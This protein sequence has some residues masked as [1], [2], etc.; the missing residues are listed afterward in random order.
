MPRVS[1]RFDSEPYLPKKSRFIAIR[2]SV[3][4]SVSP[5]RLFS[6]F[7]SFPFF[8]LLSSDYARS[9]V[10]FRQTKKW[11]RSYPERNWITQSLPKRNPTQR[12]PLERIPLH[13]AARRSVIE[14]ELSVSETRLRRSTTRSRRQAGRQASE[15]TEDRKNHPGVDEE[16]NPPENSPNPGAI[17]TAMST[18]PIVLG[19]AAASH[20]S[21]ARAS[22][23]GLPQMSTKLT[24]RRAVGAAR[25][26][27]GRVRRLREPLDWRIALSTQSV[28]SDFRFRTATVEVAALTGEMARSTSSVG[29]SSY[30]KT[31]SS[32]SPQ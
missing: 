19:T 29:Q 6:I 14:L 32:Y 11:S 1:F 24:I 31:F 20:S 10:P 27:T 26:P 8:W 3:R 28:Q 12:F 18:S 25:R 21:R 30:G 17:S 5:S 15:R 7:S 23:V 13:G 9:L 22:S 16:N 2:P 4:P